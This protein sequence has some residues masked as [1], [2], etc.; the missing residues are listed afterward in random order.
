MPKINRKLS[1]WKGILF[2]SAFEV[3]VAKQLDKLGLKWE[4][5]PESFQWF[6]KPVAYTPDFRVTREDGS[7]FYIEAKG[8][9]YTAARQKMKRVHELH[10]DVD[11]RYVF[12]D[13][14]KKLNSSAK[15]R[16]TTYADWCSK[17][18]AKWCDQTI[19]KAW[20]TSQKE[21][22][23][24]ELVTKNSVLRDI[25]K[26][27]GLDYQLGR[28]VEECGELITAVEH[29]RRSR[30]TKE[31]FLEECADVQIVLDQVK[32][33]EKENF[34]KLYEKKLKRLTS[35]FKAHLK[36]LEEKNNV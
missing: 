19:P 22:A 25:V 36:S 31:D 14:K 16:P 11:I 21:S 15:K 26:H 20:V 4:Y 18:K 27:N 5:E 32:T 13:A 3:E 9:F 28:L 8:Y 6:S 17:V 34:N 23:P 33:L 1:K 30:T 12:M 2:K 35:R 29:L 10:P 24:S 7:V